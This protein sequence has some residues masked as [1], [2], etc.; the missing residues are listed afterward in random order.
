[1]PA[2]D[3]SRLR[4]KNRT[5]AQKRGGRLPSAAT[6]RTNLVVPR[7]GIE[8]AQAMPF[9]PQEEGR[10]RMASYASNT[11]AGILIVGAALL[12]IVLVSGSLAS[13]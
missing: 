11:L 1:M 7:F 13:I 3:H 4:I 5:A 2:A 10:A 12:A 8:I 9:G 6:A